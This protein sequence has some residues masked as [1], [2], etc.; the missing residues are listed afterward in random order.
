MA[1]IDITMHG[2]ILIASV[3]GSLTAD[4][5]IAVVERYYSNGIVKHVIW[6]LTNGSLSLISTN[7]FKA[8]ASATFKSLSGETRQ[9]GKTVFVGTND[10][11]YG[12][13]RMYSTIA[14]MT[15]V[16]TKYSVY[17]TMEEAKSW[18]VDVV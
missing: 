14:E 13:M 16:P 10:T 9:G 3:T 12:L 11:E 1:A 4:E 15:G 7:G 8:I 2:N 5:V 6:D 18:L 17:R